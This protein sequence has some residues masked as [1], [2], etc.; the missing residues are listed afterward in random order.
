M[1]RF[2]L[3][4]HQSGHTGR[5]KMRFRTYVS[6]DLQFLEVKTKN[7]HG[8]TKK[9]RIKVFD[10]DLDDEGKRAFLAEHLRYD[11]ADLQP[12]IRNNFE[13]ITLVNRAKTGHV[14]VLRGKRHHSQ[15]P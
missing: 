11:I 10:M 15:Y 2:S 14:R 7:N 1:K 5:Q 13:R 6:S 9:K 3:L 8:R 12:A 4:I